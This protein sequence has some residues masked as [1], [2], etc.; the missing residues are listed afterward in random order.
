MVGLD[1]R[2]CIILWRVRAAYGYRWHPNIHWLRPCT[3]M[4][5]MMSVL[6]MCRGVS[7]HAPA[8]PATYPRHPRTNRGCDSSAQAVRG[9]EVRSV[10]QRL[11]DFLLVRIRDTWSDLQEHQA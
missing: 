7:R 5:A 9:G 2:V 10:E 11:R 3:T 4:R 6:Q 1:R 8:F